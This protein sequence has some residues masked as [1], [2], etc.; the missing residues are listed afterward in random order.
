MFCKKGTLEIFGK[1]DWETLVLESLLL[2]N[3]SKTS[4]I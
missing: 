1:C 4:V 3:D 2:K